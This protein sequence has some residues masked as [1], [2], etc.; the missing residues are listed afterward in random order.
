[1]FFSPIPLYIN[2]S[3]LQSYGDPNYHVVK[4]Y[5]DPGIGIQYS[6]DSCANALQRS[7]F[8]P[9][10]PHKVSNKRIRGLSMYL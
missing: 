3:A 2:P 1:M 6:T 7:N 8:T 9:R 4:L 5:Q 10:V